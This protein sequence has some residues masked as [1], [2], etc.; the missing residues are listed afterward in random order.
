MQ[1]VNAAQHSFQTGFERRAQPGIEIRNRD[2]QVRLGRNFTRHQGAWSAKDANTSQNRW[3]L[4]S[5]VSLPEAFW[6]FDERADRM[7]ESRF[8]RWDNAV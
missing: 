7:G 5:A 4:T 3:L 6:R 8:S 1:T 2:S